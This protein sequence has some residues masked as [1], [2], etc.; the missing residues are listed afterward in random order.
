MKG[1]NVLVMLLSVPTG[2]K[3]T[4]WIAAR[5]LHRPKRLVRRTSR[6][7]DRSSEWA[8]ERWQ[9]VPHDLTW[10]SQ[11]NDKNQCT[12]AW[13]Q[14]YQLSLPPMQRSAGK[15]LRNNWWSQTQGCARLTNQRSRST[16]CGTSQV[17]LVAEVFARDRA[18]SNTLN[19]RQS[20]T[21]VRETETSQPVTP[22]SYAASCSGKQSKDC[23]S[24]SSTVGFTLM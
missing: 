4:V 24:S 20:G 8:S 11:S 15:S 5:R 16:R 18:L 7:S 1:R 6:N 19:C 10:T 12:T 3:V 17:R 13:N 22:V 9:A 2:E 23:R 14:P 21:P